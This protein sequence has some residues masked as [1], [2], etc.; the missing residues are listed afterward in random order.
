MSTDVPKIRRKKVSDE[1]ASSATADKVGT[2]YPS[3]GTSVGTNRP[4]APPPQSSGASSNKD[5]VSK[6]LLE[7]NRA[8]KIEKSAKVKSDKHSRKKSSNE[9]VSPDAG[10]VKKSRVPV[11]KPH[12]R[13]NRELEETRR[14]REGNV[15]TAA[16]ARAAR[17]KHQAGTVK[18]VY[19]PMRVD[20]GL[21]S[22]SRNASF[23]KVSFLFIGAFIA[24]FVL[25]IYSNV[26]IDV[27]VPPVDPDVERVNTI[28]SNSTEPLLI[29]NLLNL[30]EAPTYNCT[31]YDR[32]ESLVEASPKATSLGLV[33]RDPIL[34][35]GYDCG[36]NLN[37]VG[38][39]VRDDVCTTIKDATIPKDKG[40]FYCVG[41]SGPRLYNET[42]ITDS[43]VEML[44][45]NPLIGLSPVLFTLLFTFF[46][47]LMAAGY[48]RKLHNIFPICAIVKL[49][50]V[51]LVQLEVEPVSTNLWVLIY[52]GFI[53]GFAFLMRPNLLRV[54]RILE[55][56]NCVMDN[57]Q[58][59]DGIVR[60]D[61]FRKNSLA[62]IVPSYF[63]IVIQGAFSLC[64]MFFA[65]SVPFNSDWS[66]DGFI[67]SVY[68]YVDTW[69]SYGLKQI[70]YLNLQLQAATVVA[71]ATPTAANQGM[72]DCAFTDTIGDFYTA[73]IVLAI[74]YFLASIVYEYSVK[75]LINCSV[76][77]W[78]FYGTP[79]YKP[80]KTGTL[81][82]VGILGFKRAM[83]TSGR[84]ILISALWGT[85]GLSSVTGEGKSAILEFI[86]SPIEATIFSLIALILTAGYKL[87]TR[88]ALVHAS[89][90]S[91]ELPSMQT[92]EATS[93]NL[94]RKIYG[95][96]FAQVGDS[97]ESRWLFITGSWLSVALGMLSLVWIDI[98]QTFSSIEYMGGYT[99][100]LLWL[101]GSLIQKPGLTV[102]IGV[103]LDTQYDWSSLNLEAQMTK[104]AI[105]GFII[106]AA[107]C[108]TLIRM[109][110]QIP[111]SAVD[112]AVFCFA[113]E[114][115]RRRKIRSLKLNRLIHVEYLDDSERIPAGCTLEKVAIV[116][117]AE[118]VPGQKIQVDVDGDMYDVT[119]P[120]GAKPGCEFEVAVAIPVNRID[121]ESEPNSDDGNEVTLGV[122]SAATKKMA[123]AAAPSPAATIVQST[124][125]VSP[126]PTVVQN[127]IAARPSPV[128]TIVQTGI[129]ARPSPVP[130]IVQTGVASRPSPVPTVVQASSPKTRL[131]PVPLQT[132]GSSI[133][134]AIQSRLAAGSSPTATIVQ[135]ADARD[136]KASSTGTF[137]A[138][139]SEVRK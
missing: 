128:P 101:V 10:K 27:K 47:S 121:W 76:A 106:V 119:I 28:M 49:F 138:R 131:S 103:L 120:P 11:E 42:F 34:N 71:P 78:Y 24:L 56:G 80:L 57:T 64:L 99:L 15:P 130:T 55:I 91:S 102:M 98:V 90:Y 60:P 36:Q 134:T 89:M 22:G 115:S 65:A 105:L 87:N 104:N 39:C 33:L 40:T 126:T 114:E 92:S 14:V 20:W 82:N 54:G 62:L 53:V 77:D 4:S 51:F 72:L 110:I 67:N 94:V 97:L 41:P 74:W 19:E 135:T 137:L 6:Q 139:V 48:P 9:V 117:P 26:N 66:G 85:F 37:R 125:R 45:D 73:V 1:P 5:P 29:Q 7:E 12:E 32:S 109:A 127:G 30:T 123:V 35:F 84:K 86:V 23:S 13:K 81:T 96:K 107:V 129:A 83:M 133:A 93:A 2:K 111:T 79:H 38:F 75:F 95:K 50:L 100:L 17:A 63:I 44:N 18:V 122:V 59:I 118:A 46:W 88:F 70:T 31:L 124:E 116:A 16:V 3:L 61:D 68:F 52:I 136:S 21:A 112:S 69:L 43:F 132:S 25:T 58:S 108:N 8:E 113:L